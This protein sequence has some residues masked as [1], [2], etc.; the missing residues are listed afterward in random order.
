MPLPSGQGCYAQ[1]EADIVMLTG[2]NWTTDPTTAY[3]RTR[4]GVPTFYFGQV[5]AHEAG[6][7]LGLLHENR[8]PAMMNASYL[9]YRKFALTGDD[10][11]IG[12]IAYPGRVVP[13]QDV[14]IMGFG[15]SGGYVDLSM[16]QL[17]AR[18]GLDEVQIVGFTV[19]NRSSVSLSNV[20]VE[21]IIDGATAATLTCAS[22][23]AYSLC[24]ASSPLRVTIP[25]S[26]GPGASVFI[27]AG[28]PGR[29]RLLATKAS[30]W[31]R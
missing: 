27:V 22:L 6:H 2:R 3:E 23:P 7:A 26:A 1:T 29:T 17:G 14:A 11:A 8:W 25:E 13:T 9:P 31:G 19:V 28:D 4:Q 18:A 30:T 15:F 10:V 20:P 5:V 21:V 24:S 16:S 12:R